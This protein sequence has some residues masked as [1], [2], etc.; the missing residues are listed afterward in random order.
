MPKLSKLVVDFPLKVWYHNLS[1]PYSWQFFDLENN[2]DQTDKKEKPKQ[3]DKTDEEATPK[4][5][6]DDKSNGQVED[7]PSKKKKDK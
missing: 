7:K 4:Q 5:K 2:N 3:D 1:K 6:V